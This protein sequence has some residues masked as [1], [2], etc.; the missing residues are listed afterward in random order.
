[1]QLYILQFIGFDPLQAGNVVQLVLVLGQR[2]IQGSVDV[3]RITR[4]V[5]CKERFR[6]PMVNRNVC[7]YTSF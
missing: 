3:K 4:H 2:R 1:M 5:A 6:Q 7:G